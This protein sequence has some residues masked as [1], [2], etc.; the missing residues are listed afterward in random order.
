MKY[1]YMHIEFLS[2]LQNLYMYNP[3]V[4]NIWVDSKN[5]FHKRNTPWTDMPTFWCVWKGCLCC[6]PTNRE[7]PS[8]QSC[9]ELL[10]S[11][12]SDSSGSRGEPAL[13]SPDMCPSALTPW[14][15]APS[16]KR[17]CCYPCY[18]MSIIKL[19]MKIIVRIQKITI[20]NNFV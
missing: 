17:A 3:N 1:N 2:R 12:R 11:P 8:W 15:P 6:W 18:L 13:W 14:A 16:R 4:L 9:G 5:N 10:C 19:R 20:N 7:G